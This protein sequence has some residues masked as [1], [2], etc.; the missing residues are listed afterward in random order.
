[1]FIESSCATG[2]P[3]LDRM[4]DIGQ[5]GV[6]FLYFNIDRKGKRH[7]AAS[8]F[9]KPLQRRANVRIETNIRVDRL[10]FENRRATSVICHSEGREITHTARR[11]ILLCAGTLESPQI[12]QRSGIGPA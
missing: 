8:A 9:L 2:L 12:L 7:S 1:A 6:G 11:E 3:R 5:G 4:I 10:V